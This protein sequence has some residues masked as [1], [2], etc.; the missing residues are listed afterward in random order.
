MTYTCYECRKPT[1]SHSMGCGSKSR[2][3]ALQWLLA[4]LQYL[5][6]EL[7]YEVYDK[8]LEEMIDRKSDEVFN[9]E[10]KQ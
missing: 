1:T 9:E 4:S 10:G 2:M 6:D 8:L 3:E 5:P 7:L